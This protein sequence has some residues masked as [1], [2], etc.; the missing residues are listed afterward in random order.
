MNTS[1]SQFCSEQLQTAIDSAKDVFEN[2]E[3]TRTRVSNDIKK[4]EAYLQQ[5][6]IKETFRFPLPKGF[7]IPEG[8]DRV[9][10]EIGLFENGSANG[11]ITEEAIVWGP[12]A[13]GRHRLLYE[14]SKWQGFMEVDV[15]GGPYFWEDST[16]S[17]ESKPLI[18]AKFEIR[19][20]MYPKLP[21]FIHALRDHLSVE[22]P[23]AS[24]RFDPD[25]IPF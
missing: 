15:A 1:N 21:D 18:E 19:K 7:S 8:P 6:G 16:L 9:P 17:R 4:L 12:A 24:K 2:F 3:E 13:G 25:E 22:D 20:R 14:L 23:K 5:Q 11:E 10:A